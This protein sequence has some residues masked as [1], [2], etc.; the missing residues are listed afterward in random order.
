MTADHLADLRAAGA[1]YA[2]AA[3]TISPH[4]ARNALALLRA[5]RMNRERRRRK[6]RSA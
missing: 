2:A 3:P 4:A 5:Q 6:Q 1:A